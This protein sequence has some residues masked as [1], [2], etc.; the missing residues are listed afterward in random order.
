MD[1][2]GLRFRDVPILTKEASHVAARSA[3]REYS[4]TGKK[5]IQRFF[6]NG[7]DLQRCR[8]SISQAIEFSALID[9]NE[10]ETGLTFS[11]VAVP[12]AKIAVHAPFGHG[13][14]PAAFIKRFGLLKYF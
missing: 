12:R 10:A 6:L 1:L 8:G 14:P 2:I 3:E 5:M 9:A 13:L 7:V 4:R 11:D